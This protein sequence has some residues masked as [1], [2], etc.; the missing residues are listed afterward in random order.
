ML[1]IYIRETK[2]YEK[3]YYTNSLVYYKERTK[4]FVFTTLIFSAIYTNA[5]KNFIQ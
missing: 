2:L 5:S 1:Q 3:K 4:S